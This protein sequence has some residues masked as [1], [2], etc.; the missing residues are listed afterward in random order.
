MT[1]SN[2][3]SVVDI[4]DSETLEWTTATLSVARGG[5]AATTAGRYAFFAGGVTGQKSSDIALD[6]VDIFDSITGT[7]NTST[8]SAP[9]DYLSATSVG[10][11]ALF[12]GGERNGTSS[13]VV[14]IYDTVSQTWS[15]PLTL[16]TPR[17][18][19]AATTV[20]NV[21]L[22]GGG[23]SETTHNRVD[24]FQLGQSNSFSESFFVS[25]TNLNQSRYATAATAV[26]PLAMFA[27]GV[28]S[29]FIPSNMVD[30]YNFGSQFD[31]A[32]KPKYNIVP[33]LECI[34]QN[35]IAQFGYRNNEAKTIVLSQ[36]SRN[37]LAP[38][39]SI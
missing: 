34:D 18:Y 21:A 2:A 39:V 7:W 23:L 37:Y 24:V 31:P 28:P 35:G 36:L 32:T 12:A 5:L 22:V 38:Q 4:F 25:Q 16:S 10:N 15:T 27:G 6:T 1:S 8:L 26:G 17:A 33:I 13:D 20:G 30:K 9:R 3:S 29:T 14:D 19:T 11:F